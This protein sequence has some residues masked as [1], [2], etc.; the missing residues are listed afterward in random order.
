MASTLDFH[1]N[2]V[3]LNQLWY[4]SHKTLMM[5][6]CIELDAVDR[7]DELT[8]KYLGTPLKIKKQKDEN[9]PKRPKSAFLFYSDE[10]RQ[11]LIKKQKDAGSSVNIGQVAKQLGLMW[12]KLSKKEKSKYEAL[13]NADK[14]RYQ[15]AIDAYNEQKHSI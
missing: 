6:L 3:Q 14:K 11:K 5:H 1:N 15:Q 12:G 13:N 8:N 10:F 9:K 7:L 2:T 4:E